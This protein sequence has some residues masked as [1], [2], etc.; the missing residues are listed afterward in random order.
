MLRIT[1]YCSA[2]NGQ[3]YLNGEPCL[4]SSVIN[5]E[6]L[7]EALVQKYKI[8]HPRFGK[9]DRLAQ[10]GFTI[11]DVVL[12]DTHLADTHDPFKLGMVLSNSA[13][14]LDTDVKYWES[15]SSIPSPALFVYTL[16]NI[17]LAEISIKNKFKGEN[18]FFISEK[19]D[20]HFLHSYISEMFE[21][22]RLEACLSGWVEV[23]ENNYN[24]FLFLIEEKQNENFS[25][26]TE[27]NIT[28]IYNKTLQWNS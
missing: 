8:T 7:I 26:F 21:N 27:E 1:K 18:Y 10:L 11:A 24:A 25:E 23:L 5:M 4:G 28:T 12:Q 6:L 19:P 22:K 17:V 16:P 3:A 20:F 15:T 13:S 9:M 14:S 2:S